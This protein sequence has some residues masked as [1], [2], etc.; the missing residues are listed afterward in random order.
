MKVMLPRTVGG[1]LHLLRLVLV[2]PLVLPIA[3][4]GADREAV[5]A[6]HEAAGSG[7]TAKVRELLKE[8]ADLLEARTPAGSTPLHTASRAGMLEVVEFLVEAGAEVDAGDN[9]NTTPL[10]LAALEGHPDVVRYLVSR[11]ADAL[12]ADDNGATALHWAAYNGHLEIVKMMVGLGADVNAL[13]VNGSH[14]LIGA[15][16]GGHTET[17]QYLI[18]QGAQLDVQNQSGYS[19]LLL[20]AFRGNEETLKALLDAGADMNIWNGWESP[21]HMAGWSGSVETMRLLLSRGADPNGKT[22]DSPTALICAIDSDNAEAVN[23]LLENGADPSGGWAT[24]YTAL[25]RAVSATDTDIIRA[26]IDHGANVNASDEN[27]TSPLDIAVR[28]GRVEALGTLIKSGAG[29]SDKDPYF[30][31]TPLHEAAASGNA[32][33]VGLLLANGSGTN[34]KDAEGYT[35]LDLAARYGHRNVADLLT[36]KGAKANNMVE[37]YGHCGLLSRPLDEGEALMWYTGHCG[38]VVKTRKNLLIFDYWNQGPDPA[39][40][41]LANGHI[42]P[43]E[44][45]DLD[46]TVFV[47]HEHG[48]H[49]DTTIFD[50]EGQVDRIRYVYGFRP[51]QI[52]QYSRTG[53]NGPGYEYVGPRESTEIGGMKI[54]TVRANDAGVGFLVEVDGVRLYHAGDHAGWAEGEKQGYIDEIDYLAGFPGRIDLAFLNVTG[55]HAH[56]PDAL[57]EGTYYT[58]NKL[59]PKAIIPTH[60]GTR[61]F[62]YA[63][64]AEQAATDGIKA[65]YACPKCRGDRFIYSSGTIRQDMRDASS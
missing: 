18:S 7:D 50:W 23:L 56:N 40:P 30:G 52:Q 9:E 62:Q 28:E 12:A 34:E 21:L 32:D 26:L 47:T 44:I 35:P 31:R 22:E 41:C 48:D 2:I 33:I 20:A 1:T 14:A 58:I 63:K 51:E 60:A 61:E 13:K 43:A 42:D 29:V 25:H 45:G 37:N 17:V 39:S 15:A 49:F 64:A 27:G 55:C 3:A 4:G 6:I 11:G 8:H 57:R 36:A 54:S 46:V 5:R 19:A 53:Y 24:G 65:P 59:S 10:G 38:W 16:Y